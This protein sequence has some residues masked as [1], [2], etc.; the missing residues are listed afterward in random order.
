M[1]TAR[2]PTAS[3][4]SE[5]G[6]P[7]NLQIPGII[8]FQLAGR[9]RSA[10]LSQKRRDGKTRYVRPNMQKKGRG[11]AYSYDVYIVKLM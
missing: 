5:W 7:G 8:P 1:G 3:V 11:M 9:C 2:N 6:G 10:A 4:T